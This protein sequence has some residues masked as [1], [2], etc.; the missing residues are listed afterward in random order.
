M[1]YK[2]NDYEYASAPKD[3]VDSQHV[4]TVFDEANSYII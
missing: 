1:A 3:H 2:V 4:D